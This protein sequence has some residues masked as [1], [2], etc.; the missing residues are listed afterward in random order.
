TKWWNSRDRTE[1]WAERYGGGFDRVQRLFKDSHEALETERQREQAAQR[2][3]RESKIKAAKMEAERQKAGAEAQLQKTR[4]RSIRW[5]AALAV[6]LAAVTLFAAINAWQRY[7]QAEVKRVE[8]LAIQTRFLASQS[9]RETTQGNT[10]GGVLL[11]LAA[12]D[13]Q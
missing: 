9:K 2:A 11:A 3:Q 7:R 1:A 12:L 10:R 6:T 8:A 5:V 4:S 13:R